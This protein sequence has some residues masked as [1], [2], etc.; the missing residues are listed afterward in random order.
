MAGTGG[1]GQNTV[2]TLRIEYEYS[3]PR[4]CNVAEGLPSLRAQKWHGDDK[5][6]LPLRRRIVASNSYYFNIFTAKK[7]VVIS[8]SVKI[9]GPQAL[10]KCA[11]MEW[12][13]TSGIAAV[14]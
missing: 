11:R 12:K 8:K 5:E 9:Y 2:E 4:L 3:I 7:K 6:V 13:A 1:S 10:S 14:V